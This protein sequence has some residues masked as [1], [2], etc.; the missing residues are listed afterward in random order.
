MAINEYYTATGYPT[1]DHDGDSLSARNEFA[2]INDGFDLMPKL[3]N[4][5]LSII[6]VNAAGTVMESV[7]LTTAKIL[8]SDGSVAATADIPLGGFK[9]TGLKQ[10]AATGEAVTFE[11]MNTADSN[12]LTSA[13]SYADIAAGANAGAIST[14]ATN[15]ANGDLANAGGVSANA[16]NITTNA[17]NLTAHEADLSNPHQNNLATFGIAR[18]AADINNLATQASANSFVTNNTVAALNGKDI[19]IAADTNLETWADTLPPQGEYDVYITITQNGLPTGNWYIKL[20]K[21]S[22]NNGYHTIVARQIT[23][24][25]TWHNTRDGT[26]NTWTGW[27]QVAERAYVDASVLN[28]SFNTNINKSTLD[29]TWSLA[30]GAV[31]SIPSGVYNLIFDADVVLQVYVNSLWRVVSVPAAYAI[32]ITSNGIDVRGYNTSTTVARNV[33]YRRL[34]A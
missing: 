13:K 29:G 21:Y 1:I 22:A 12:T 15:R 9:I 32:N 33:Y 31:L 20:F 7:T 19:N 11:Q 27:S 23:T 34:I 18:S 2:K 25:E 16:G 5:G 24:G 14:E 26:T 6:R 10:G 28:L 8:A 4:S 17:N 30:I 3:L